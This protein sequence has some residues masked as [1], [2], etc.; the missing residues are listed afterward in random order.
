MG[1][2]VGKIISVPVII[3]NP[4]KKIEVMIGKEGWII[5]G[6]TDTH[7]ELHDG[8][9]TS[10]EIERKDSHLLYTIDVVT[11]D[12]KQYNLLPTQTELAA[13]SG[14][15]NSDFSVH[16]RVHEWIKKE[17]AFVRISHFFPDEN[18]D[19]KIELTGEEIRRLCYLLY[20]K[21]K[22]GDKEEEW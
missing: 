7:I 12:N 11:R 19:K 3:T 14:M 15:V 13:L 8:G 6:V 18:R 2:Y 1:V 10:M 4:M 20:L 16:F 22:H 17:Y 5:T 9:K 21:G